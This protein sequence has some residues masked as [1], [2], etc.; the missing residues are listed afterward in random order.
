M[1]YSWGLFKL[2]APQ[3]IVLNDE[4]EL[5]VELQE[6]SRPGDLTEKLFDFNPSISFAFQPADKAYTK[7]DNYLGVGVPDEYEHQIDQIIAILELDEH[8]AWVEGNEDIELNDPTTKQ[9]IPAL[10]KNFGFNDPAVG[11]QWGLEKM[12]FD[13]L[14]GLMKNN[15]MK[16]KKQALLVIL[17]TGVDANHEDLKANYVSIQESSDNDPRGHG[18]H[19]AGIAAAVS[20]NQIG[21]VSVNPNSDFV[22]IS[23]IKVLNSSGV[24]SQKRIIDGIIKAADAGADVISM[25]LGGRSSK[26]KQKAYDQAIEYAND[27]GAIVVVAAGNNGGNAKE[28]APANATGVITVTALKQDLSKADFSNHIKD[29]KMGISAPGEG[30]YSTLPNDKYASLNGT[31][32]ATPYVSGLVAVMKAIDPSLTT[33]E[34]YEILSETGK[35]TKSSNQTGNIIQVDQALKAVIGN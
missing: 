9:K 28:I 2:I 15:K 6:G 35:S 29:I 18:T 7:L 5:L 22:R 27:K 1:I 23:S 11:E 17:D 24:G 26:S 33:S 31:S 32:M 8:V 30:I 12:G 10:K 16:A 14:Q 13:Q 3:E 19:C 20:N 4:Y 34:V 25:S 21:I